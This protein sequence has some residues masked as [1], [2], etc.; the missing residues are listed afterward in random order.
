M[1]RS[2]FGGD[3]S[4]ASAVEFA[5]VVPVFLTMLFGIIAYGIYF[6][7]VHST[8]QLAADAA[9]A[10]V[11]GLSD[12]ERTAIATAHVRN[13]V[14]AYVLLNPERIEVTAEPLEA[15]ARQFRVS[16]RYDASLLPIWNFTPFLP[17]PERIIERTATIQR[18][19]Y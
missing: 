13:N 14:P 11:A 17:L 19:G 1:G 16:V 9:R 7:A 6:G 18:G 3:V 4:G 2:S 15:D 10:S 8:S 12:A 5:I